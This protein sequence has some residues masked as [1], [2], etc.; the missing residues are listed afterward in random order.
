MAY[1]W[2]EWDDECLA[3]EGHDYRNRRIIL[4][5][6]GEYLGG[7]KHS[8]CWHSE[9]WHS[10][11]GEKSTWRTH[12]GKVRAEGPSGPPHP[13]CTRIGTRN[14]GTPA[15]YKLCRRTKTA[16]TGRRLHE[17]GP[18]GNCWGFPGPGAPPGAVA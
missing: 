16:G 15:R 18:A 2:L 11:L 9:C 17:P 10:A 7:E 6:T 14:V 3:F 8:E 13:T 1:T 12:H 4:E 5:P